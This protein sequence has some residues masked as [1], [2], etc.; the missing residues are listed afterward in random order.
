MERAPPTDATSGMRP[1]PIAS[2]ATHVATFPKRNT[3]EG[4]RRNV[5][6][7][8]R[9]R[10]TDGAGRRDDEE[11]GIEAAS[12]RRRHVRRGRVDGWT[13]GREGGME[14]EPTPFRSVGR[15]SAEAAAAS[16]AIA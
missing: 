14:W 15:C 5:K 3:G 8:I 11:E 1:D 12:G 16:C 7:N 2:S 4:G 9:V 10:D 13:G 6:N